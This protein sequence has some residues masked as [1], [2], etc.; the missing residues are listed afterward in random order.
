MPGWDVLQQPFQYHQPVA[1]EVPAPDN[2]A[3]KIIASG[4]A[5]ENFIRMA[6]ARRQ[7]DLEQQ[8]QIQ[9]AALTMRAQDIA[10]ENNRLDYLVGM[11]NANSLREYRMGSGIYGNPQ[12][13]AA[14]AAAIREKYRLN[15]EA[16]VASQQQWDEKGLDALNAAGLNNEELW[17]T[18]PVK[19]LDAM[20][21]WMG[22][23]G[24]SYEGALHQ[25]ALR[26]KAK[27][28]L[29]KIRVREGATFLPGGTSPVTGVYV[30]PVWQGGETR[31]VPLLEF[32]KR[33][34]DNP[35]ERDI[36]IQNA[37]AAGVNTR[38]IDE[39]QSAEQRKARGYPAVP[40]LVHKD[41][42]VPRVETIFKESGTG[43]F[44]RGPN[45]L[46]EDLTRPPKKE[47][48]Y[49][50]EQFPTDPSLDHGELPAP[51][52]PE[53]GATFPEP[54][55]PPNVPGSSIESPSG[56]TFGPGGVPVDKKTSFNYSP[57]R[58]ET[59][60]AQA[61]RALQYNPGARD[62]IAR[63]LSEMQINPNLLVT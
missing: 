13:R 51:D 56:M 7:A 45:Q 21:D 10:A 6:V 55:A 52:L 41:T 24:N 60:L 16:R 4:S 31:D 50:N 38:I 20:E 14:A 32:A 42:F 57:T 53:S 26:L 62:E 15:T 1:P 2:T 12:A 17:H 47:V 29:L 58:T 37:R 61:R 54:A 34:R 48:D 40:T 11:E 18:N 35:D 46:P 23:Y 63:R 43:K 19:Q 27:A 8:Q 9:Q 59:V 36:L 33:W 49:F 28:D 25:E 44:Q 30:P 5:A 39:L 22:R 3:A